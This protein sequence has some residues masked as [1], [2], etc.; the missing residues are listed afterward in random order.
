MNKKILIFVSIVFVLI[1]GSVSA[2]EKPGT[3]VFKLANQAKNAVSTL[4][5]EDSEYPLLT[6]D[7]LQG[8]DEITYH[9][10]L[11]ADATATTWD[12]F[13]P[14]V[15]DETWT[16][17]HWQLGYTG[18]STAWVSR[19][20]NAV[21]NCQSLKFP[22]NTA[23]S[24]SRGSAV[25]TAVAT[26]NSLAVI[27]SLLGYIRASGSDPHSCPGPIV[28]LPYFS[29]ATATLELKAND[30]DR[31][32]MITIPFYVEQ[33]CRMDGTAYVYIL[34]S[35]LGGTS[36]PTPGSTPVVTLTHEAQIE[37]IILDA[38]GQASGSLFLDEPDELNY[39]WGCDIEPGFHTLE[40]SFVLKHYAR[41]HASPCNPNVT[42]SSVIND[43][44]AINIAFTE[45]SPV[46]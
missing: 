23:E 5:S 29:D 22:F 12:H 21:N 19:Q 44:F 33:A 7:D 26:N 37:W 6:Y 42:I 9:V 39:G 31:E 3:V 13:C 15:F 17:Q 36:K 18:A 11:R 28:N 38:C 24:E 40:V 16:D 25:V 45:A 46:N 1:L 10:K 14:P 20:V 43:G 34:G 27:G 30:D 2:K 4:S 35:S 32:Y 41:I 8:E